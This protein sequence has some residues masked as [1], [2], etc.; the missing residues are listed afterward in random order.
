M[1]VS[2]RYSEER[3][4]AIL[5]KLQ[6]PYNRTVS[7]LAAE[8]GVSAATIY[9]WH[10][11]EIS[12][13]SKGKARQPYEFVVKAGIATTLKGNFV[14]GARS[15]AGN[16]YDGHTLAEQMG[17]GHGADARHRDDILHRLC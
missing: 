2:M 12:C 11:P 10:A 16:P 17:A 9:N 3:K 6:A 15:F 5:A 4:Q 14:V 8:E 7:D 13:I 1:K